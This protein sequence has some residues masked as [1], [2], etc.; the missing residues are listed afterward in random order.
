[1]KKQLPAKTEQQGITRA[2]EKMR[3]PKTSNPQAT[4]SSIPHQLLLEFTISTLLYFTI[5]HVDFK[6]EKK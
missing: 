1:M 2:A 5:L 6:S 4:H 3:Q